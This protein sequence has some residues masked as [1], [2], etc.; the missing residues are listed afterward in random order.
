M[1]QFSTPSCDNHCAVQVSCT[2]TSMIMLNHLLICIPCTWNQIG[3]TRS[4]SSHPF[5]CAL[6]ISIMTSH[7]LICIPCTWNQMHVDCKSYGNKG[8]STAKVTWYDLGIR[9]LVAHY[10]KYSSTTKKKFS[11]WTCVITILTKTA[12]NVMRGRSGMTVIVLEKELVFSYFCVY[13]KSA[14]QTAMLF[15]MQNC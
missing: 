5:L 3:V 6:V 15:R 12:Q 7:L 14:V 2:V 1:F 4:Y 11:F 13:C 9:P 10:S 8:T